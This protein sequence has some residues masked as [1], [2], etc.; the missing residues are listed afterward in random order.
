M[1]NK[2]EELFQIRETKELTA[3]GFLSLE[4]ALLGQRGNLMSKEHF[5]V[6]FLP[7]IVILRLGESM[8]LLLGNKH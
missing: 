6:N 8:S 5:H 1:E 3:Q 7:L 4:E 2:A